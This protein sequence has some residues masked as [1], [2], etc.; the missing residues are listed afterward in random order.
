MNIE[1]NLEDVCLDLLIVRKHLYNYNCLFK[2]ADHIHVGVR[3]CTVQYIG[4]E[5]MRRNSHCCC[6]LF[7]NIFTC[8]GFEEC[9]REELPI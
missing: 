6:C 8:K 2:A 3:T 9:V 1:I 5:Y 7:I 4:R